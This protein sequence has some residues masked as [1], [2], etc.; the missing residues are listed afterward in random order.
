MPELHNTKADIADDT[1]QTGLSQAKLLASLG[2]V[3][4]GRNEGERLKRCLDS[5]GELSRNVVYV[6]SGS[7][8]ESIMVG[9][10]LTAAVVEL[11]LESPFTAARARNAGFNKLLQLRPNLQYVFFVDGDCE[12]ANDWLSK[13][14]NFLYQQER[15]AVV[16][17]FRRERYPDQSIYNMLCDYEWGDIVSGETKICGGDALI[18]V[19]AFQQVGGYRP[20]LI[21]GEE[22]EM[23]V[24]LRKLGWQIWRLSIPMTLHDAAMFHFEQWW[25]RSLRGGYAFAQGAALHGNSK[26]RHGVLETV[27]AWFWGLIIPV[28]SALL[29]LAFGT[30]GLLLLAIYPMQITRIALRGKRTVR[31]NWLRATALVVGKFAE[32][33]GQIKYLGDRVRGVRSG[34]IEYK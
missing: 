26:D 16:W 32:I 15:V 28:V 2:V 24:R 23:C 21:C 30:W 4:I 12:V 11:D 1:D 19:S 25:K 27:R 8:D 17:G 6:D 7:T 18:R 14:S 10:Q 22:P 29:T 33:F 20:D 3:A 9:Q 34:L 5:V 31:E 13:A